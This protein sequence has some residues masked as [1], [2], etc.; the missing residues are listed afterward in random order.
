M[1]KN[2]KYQA[3]AS[4]QIS[5][6]LN[7]VGS[8]LNL[9]KEIEDATSEL[10]S[11]KQILQDTCREVLES[12]GF[13]YAAIQ[14][15][16]PE[17]KTIE[18]L[19]VTRAESLRSNWKDWTG[20]A[21]HSLSAADTSLQDI[22][23]EIALSLNP[24]HLKIVSG[25]Y[26]QFDRWIYEEFEHKHCVRTW[27]PIVIIRD[28]SG[29]V[30]SD[31]IDR[32]KGKVSFE[33]EEFE[34]IDNEKR[35]GYRI[36]ID[37][38]IPLEQ[39]PQWD[40]EI[41]GTIDAGYFDPPNEYND[42]KHR[43]SLMDA[44]RLVRFA[45]IKA[46]T[47]RR[48]LLPYVLEITA[49]RAREIV[50]ADSSTLHFLR[51]PD[52]T[53]YI[54]EV[55]SGNHSLNLLQDCPPRF[56]DDGLGYTAIKKKKPVTFSESPSLPKKPKTRTINPKA[57]EIG[58][59]AV[60]A[61]PVLVGEQQGVLYVNFEKPHD[62]STQETEMV[63]FYA[64]RAMAAIRNAA[65]Y[66]KTQDDARVLANLN[67]VSHSL[68]D[69]PEGLL[70]HIAGS[71]INI[72]AADII[73]IFE[74]D[75]TRNKM[76]SPANI[77]GRLKD[78]EIAEEDR[79]NAIKE[80]MNFLKNRQEMYFTKD[81]LNDPI[82]YRLKSKGMDSR[83]ARL[84]K[85]E[86]IKAS[87]WILLR[88]GE[89]IFGVMFIHYRGSH[90]FHEDEKRII[91][92]L[93]SSAAMA[94]KNRRIFGGLND[95]QKKIISTL[96]I[97]ELLDLIVNQAAR[98]TVAEV[99]DIR[100]LTD[101]ISQN[102]KIEAKY[103]HEKS[104]T[105][106]SSYINVSGEIAEYTAK[107]KLPVLIQN[108]NT[109][110]R[111]KKLEGNTNMISMLSVPL[112]D[113]QGHILGILTVGKGNSCFHKREQQILEALADLAVIGI[114]NIERQKQFAAAN[115]MAS[116]G[117]L[118]GGWVHWLKNKIGA[119][120]VRS[121]DIQA[122]GDTRTKGIAAEIEDMTDWLLKQALKLQN[123]I[124]GN[125]ETIDISNTV[126]SAL[127]QVNPPESIRIINDLHGENL[128]KVLGGKE[129]IITA[130]SNIIQNSV[131]AMPQ[132]GKLSISGER[133]VHAGRVWCVINL[134]DTG[135][136]ITEKDKENIFSLGYSTKTTDMG[137]DFPGFGLWWTST[138]FERIGGQLT[139]ESEEGSGS[140]FTVILPEH[141]EN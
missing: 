126:R 91:D 93:A 138:Y 20:V 119:I 42:L 4:P 82:M 34:I 127:T 13:D 81:F 57:R 71:T 136:G 30:I 131:E 41:I 18:T 67:S 46:L 85:T 2:N 106:H 112:L 77:T 10:F 101:P 132:G 78:R 11:L 121:Q 140:Q 52:E 141:S 124:L 120:R 74:Y 8:L 89:E 107:K 105:P 99:G 59:Q 97:E 45:A 95:T 39:D 115:A 16:R 47:I 6:S 139:V 129:Q 87:T 36:E 23:A 7:S 73:N 84:L 86:H 116:L 49:E 83:V 62:F 35:G 37:M 53:E 14:L 31:W 68:I 96:H 72:L 75:Q 123:L 63:G 43:I 26:K 134:T 58:V 135:Q 12:Q 66:S 25:W 64:S 32:W 90:Q 5:D 100:L 29:N 54:Y 113:S 60:A 22:Q 130:F 125:Q 69:E 3:P 128:P 109:D 9:V 133:K 110:K 15:I 65:V 38:P 88:V 50:K 98:I 103:A 1:T 28:A 17:D 92:I 80:I 118:A 44:E 114:K 56:S 40:M 24:P 48:A 122:I 94:I 55:Y 21:K 102:L 104:S 19:H 137:Q 111:F 61:F 33:S 117:D 70:H 79:T 27:V 51:N 76:L 108:I